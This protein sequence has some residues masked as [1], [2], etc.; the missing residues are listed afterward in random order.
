MSS[1]SQRVL[2]S[3]AFASVLS[4]A[5]P[6]PAG[7][8]LKPGDTLLTI[9]NSLSLAKD[10]AIPGLLNALLVSQ[11]LEP[12]KWGRLSK[13]ARG[14]RSH[15]ETP[16]YLTSVHKRLDSDGLVDA[17][18][19]AY[20]NIL[21]GPTG[22]GITPGTRWDFVC[23]QGFG[24]DDS[25]PAADD[26]AENA[27]VFNAYVRRFDMVI[28][29]QGGQTVLFARY[30]NKPA[31]D[32]PADIAAYAAASDQLMRNYNAI[33][34]ELG[35]VVVPIAEVMKQAILERPQGAAPHYL[36]TSQA[37][38]RIH[39]GPLAKG[40]YAYTFYAALTG[41]SP[42]GLALKHGDY[43]DSNIETRPID[44]LLE[45]ISWNAVE[46]RPDRVNL[47][48]DSTGEVRLGYDPATGKATISISGRITS[49]R[50]GT[51]GYKKM[52]PSDGPLLG[53][54]KAVQ[55]DDELVAWHDPA[56]VPP[57]TY[58]LERLVIAGTPASDVLL[59]FTSSAGDA[60][61]VSPD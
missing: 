42:L 10:D 22:E 33:G 37:N 28:R 29:K 27:A 6:L 17:S 24:S 51:P 7:E 21:T 59:C 45:R 61:A 34:S 25:E 16:S 5:T 40:V 12:L 18:K 46:A 15:H 9:G 30:G 47:E 43:D 2:R 1:F 54:L 48:R 60:K 38:D 14:L 57:G 35:A 56:G 39:P 13:W 20:A 36:Y 44:D 8:P 19:G 31:T 50:L 23:L 26:S 55:S 32:S 4:L 3:V 52:T 41:K 11:Q 58:V 53:N 49:I